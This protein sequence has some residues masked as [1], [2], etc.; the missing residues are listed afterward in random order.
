M[1]GLFVTIGIIMGIIAVIWL[2]AAQYFQKG[3]RYVSYFDESVQG[4]SVDSSVKYRGVEVGRVERINVAPDNRLIEVVMKIDLEEKFAENTVAQLKS[5][6]ITGLVFIELNRYDKSIPDRVRIEFE[7]PYPVIPSRESEISRIVS[8]IDTVMKRITEID[9]EDSF[10]KIKRIVDVVESVV[11]DEKLQN[12]LANLNESAAR[13]EGLTREMEKTMR[14]LRALTVESREIIGRLE[15][16]K[17]SSSFNAAAVEMKQTLSRVQDLVAEIT[18]T[19]RGMEFAE[20]SEEA[21]SLMSDLDNSA[22]L[23]A[24]GIRDASES[25]TR[26]ARSLETLVQRLSENP[27]DIIFGRSSR[28][29]RN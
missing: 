22:R 27:S 10:Q 12:I 21:E 23:A 6:G 19:I 24:V 16:E 28:E 14:E 29:R 2:G 18:E 26:A 25:V 4:L 1:I 5:V 20:R 7:A 3:K 15:L 9:I 8:N 11:T 13:F 17:T